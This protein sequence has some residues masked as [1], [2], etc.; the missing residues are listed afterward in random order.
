MIYFDLDGVLRDICASANWNP[1]SWNEK[2]EG[3][4]IITWFNEHQ[5]LLRHAP[6]TEYLTHV[7]T[8]Y[9]ELN[10]MTTQPKSWQNT[11]W[12][13]VQDNIPCKVNVTIAK[14]M[15]KLDLLKPEDILVE[16]NPN[17]P[18]YSQIILIDRPY[19]RCVTLP[20]I[21]VYTPTAMMD[22]LRRR[23]HDRL[24]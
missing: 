18:D 11:M 13:W 17:L 8:E 7:L 1:Q 3:K 16:D 22:E 24:D 14:F 19:N 4:S 20:H 2:I 10:I 6:V 12:L 15:G 23:T 9:D 21:R 5:S